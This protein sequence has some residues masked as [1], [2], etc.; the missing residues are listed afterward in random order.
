[1]EN[2]EP[3]ASEP[4]CLLLGLVLDLSEKNNG[5]LRPTWPLQIMYLQ[6]S[7]KTRETGPEHYII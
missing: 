7:F 4:F 3:C 6:N 5:L 2:S 1:M